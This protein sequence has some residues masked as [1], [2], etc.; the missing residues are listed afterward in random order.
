MRALLALAFSLTMLGWMPQASSGQEPGSLKKQMEAIVQTHELARDRFHD[1]LVGKTTEDATKSAIEAYHEAVG[2]NT[3]AVLDLVR[4]NPTDPSVVEALKFV[5]TTA[6]A[7]PGNQSYLAMEILLRDHA[8]DPK[9]GDLCASLIIF[10]DA[11]IAESLM[12]SVLENNPSR[13]VQ[14]SVSYSLALYLKLQARWMRRVRANP[15]SFIRTAEEHQKTDEW[16]TLKDV[17]PAL[18]DREYEIQLERILK[19]FADV[20]VKPDTRPLGVIAEGELFAFRN[21]VVGKVAPEI[22]GKDSSGE[23]FSLNDFRG[24]VVVLT[25]SGN[26]CG[27]CVAM[28]PDERELVATLKERPFAMI[29]VNTDE[30]VEVLR[31][32]IASGDITWRCWWDGGQEG[33]ITTRWGITGFPSIFVLDPNGVI[34]FKDLRGDDLKQAVLRLLEE[35]AQPVGPASSLLK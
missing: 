35:S 7:G 3:D 25:F 16:R 26:W 32:S 17:D 13:D 30:N 19:D 12:R 2:R 27:P 6:R 28:Y 33:P 31:K 11:P 4:A 5:I 9:M 15:T 22:R 20:R 14:G 24:K 1:E 34:R 18:I 29:S 23:T 8:R 21:L 10:S